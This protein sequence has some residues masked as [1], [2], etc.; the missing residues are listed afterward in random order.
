MWDFIVKVVC[1]R[2]WRL[3]FS[4]KTKWILQEDSWEAIPQ[5]EPRADHMTEMQRVMT[6]SFHK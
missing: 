6:T 2:E 5:S 4:L 1:E 3:K